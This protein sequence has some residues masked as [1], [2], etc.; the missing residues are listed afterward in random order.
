ML[1][2]LKKTK[3][4]TME[5]YPPFVNQDQHDFYYR[6]IAALTAAGGW[7]IDFVNKKSYLDTAARDILGLP[8][9][10]KASLYKL[11]E[12]YAPGKHREKAIEVFM[13]C[14]EGTPF[15]TSIKMLKPNGTEFWVSSRGKPIYNEKDE[16][17]GVQGVFRDIDEEKRKEIK[18]KKSYNLIESQNK[19]LY[20][21]AHIV[22]HNLRSHTSNLQ[23]TLTLLDAVSSKEE[24]QELMDG[25]KEISASL[26]DTIIHL[27]EIVSINT[28][29]IAPTKDV[30]FQKTLDGVLH[31]IHNLVNES[32]TKIKA[33]FEALQA[34]DYFPAYLESILLNLITNGITYKHP[35]RNAEINITTCVDNHV[36]K[37]IV[38]DNGL[39]IDLDT[40]GEKIFNMY[41][42]FH[43]NE[44]AVGIGLFITKNQVEAMGGTIEVS[45]V[46]NKGTTFTI[47]LR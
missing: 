13:A 15:S 7:S 45:S 40:F 10:Y 44:N 37:L 9:N 23:L 11:I 31:S 42:T 1:N 12:L 38:Q 18:L 5:K 14:S 46:V 47:V 2:T 41:Q 43:R 17:V 6:Q 30:S 36:K 3:I 29:D 32:N 21:F 16:V 28:K 25:L 4:G 35:D 34:I 8:D 39:G 19:R 33:D 20:N 27:S 22:S 26:S 24:E